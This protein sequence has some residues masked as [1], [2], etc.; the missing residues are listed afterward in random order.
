[1]PDKDARYTMRDNH[2]FLGSGPMRVRLAET[3]LVV[4]SAK[5]R[6]RHCAKTLPTA[7]DLVLE[8][9]C[10]TG[11]ATRT[12]AAVAAR[13][14]AVDRSVQFVA[15]LKEQMRG[16]DNA[17]IECLDGRNIPALAALMPEP[18]VVFIDIGGDAQLDNVSLQLRLCLR[19]FAPRLVV[20]RSFELATLAGLIGHVEPPP[21][22]GLLPAQGEPVGRDALSHLIELAGSASIDARCFAARRLNGFDDAAARRCVEELAADP[23]P[24][25]RRAV[26]RV[27]GGHRPEEGDRVQYFEDYRWSNLQPTGMRRL[28]APPGTPY[29]R[30][31]RHGEGVRVEEYDGRG[32][33]VRL[34]H[35]PDDLRWKRDW[36]KERRADGHSAVVYDADDS[37]V[38]YER[39]EFLAETC[40][41]GPLVRSET[42][43]VDGRLIETQ[44]PQKVSHTAYDLYVKDSCGKLKGVIHHAGVD[45]GEPYDITEDWEK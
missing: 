13:V 28:G 40:A 29:F 5:D 26:E 2:A 31:M 12:L 7:E 44:E 10:S 14:V 21:A 16:V 20:V 45:K 33:F 43:N 39:Y 4:V 8:I 36:R 17:V 19:A 3:E 27:R 35:H 24:R 41:D 18:T 1:M 23:E 32:A 25:V 6:F 15:E 38:L 11:L 34:C 42:F 30:F 9:G 22:S 37:V